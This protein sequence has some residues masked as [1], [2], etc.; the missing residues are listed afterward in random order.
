MAVALEDLLPALTASLNVP[1]A[2][3]PLFN[4]TD[5]NADVWIAA[6]ANGFWFAW[7]RGFY[8]GYRLDE[9]DENIVA[10]DGGAD[11]GRGDQQIIIIYTA[12]EAIRAEMLSMFTTT[13]DKAGPTETERQRS[14]TLLKQLLDDRR[15]ELE[16]IRTEAV[17]GGNATKVR[18]IDAVRARSD[19]W[20]GC[21]PWVR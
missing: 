16:E 8:R 10:V 20:S 14:S 11:L 7:T 12:F 19:M 15:A 5:D 6:L 3:R 13:R 2:V 1:G 9:T 4:I 17:N 21:Y 18:I